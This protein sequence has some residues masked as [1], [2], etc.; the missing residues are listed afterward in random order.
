MATTV[1]ATLASSKLAV[2]QGDLHLI[3]SPVDQ[4]VLY[5]DQA[6]F[7]KFLATA[8]VKANKPKKHHR[9]ARTT[10]ARYILTASSPHGGPFSPQRKAASVPN[11]RP[12]ST[13]VWSRI[14]HP[15]GKTG[16]PEGPSHPRL[17]TR[18]IDHHGRRQRG[19]ESPE[20]PRR[21]V[22]HH[23]TPRGSAQPAA[24]ARSADLK[25]RPTSVPSLLKAV[26]LQAT[27]RASADPHRGKEPF[28]RKSRH[29]PGDAEACQG[30]RHQ[31]KDG[32]RKA[33]TAVIAG[34]KGDPKQRSGTSATEGPRRRSVFD[35]LSFLHEP[36]TE[37]RRRLCGKVVS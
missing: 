25:A 11:E 2:T 21:Q 7:D 4:L 23:N 37:K 30:S 15:A 3:G 24:P 17:G 19:A 31:R 32:P 18:N 6:A 29:A 8:R 22:R 34:L 27:S 20:P 1:G 9:Q 12:I 10:D 16:T 14:G 28:E 35:R 13:S 36:Q 26:R 5:F 33:Q